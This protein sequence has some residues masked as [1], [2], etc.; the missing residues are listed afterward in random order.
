MN[1]IEMNANVLLAQAIPSL[2][3]IALP[4]VSFTRN[5]FAVKDRLPRKQWEPSTEGTPEQI[6][7]SQHTGCILGI[8]VRKVV[9]DTIE[10]QEGSDREEG[11]TDDGHNP[12]CTSRRPAEPEQADRNCE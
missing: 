1:A 8:C 6:V 4:V 10:Q 2:E 12:V 7:S 11:R 5:G 3:Y 9:E